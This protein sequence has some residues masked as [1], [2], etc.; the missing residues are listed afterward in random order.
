MVMSMAKITAGDGYT[1]LTRHVA[2]GD[3]PGQGMHDATAY[4][5]AQGNPPGR[6][7][8]RG[9]PL[10]G[11]DSQEVTEEQMRL[12]FGHG[13]HPDGEAMITAYINAHTHP[14]MTDV[15]LERVRQAAI[16]H[17]TLGRQFPAYKTIE[18]HGAR[19][20]RR[21][22]VIR[23]ETGRD[24]T[25]AEEKKVQA[26]ESRRHRAPVAGFDLAFTPVKSASLLWALDERP[27]VRAAIR[28]A[29]AGAITEALELIEDHAAY[30]RTGTGGIAQIATSG[31]TGA[32]F[33][34][35]DSRAGDPNLHTHVAISA[36][37]QGT[38][39]TWRALDARG[40]Y[41]LRVAASE[42]YNTA[43]EARLTAALGV[44]FAPRPG[45]GGNGKDP[46]RE[47]DGVPAV[48]IT[49]FSRRRAAIEARYDT[50]LAGYRARHGHDP[51]HAASR[52]LAQQA[53]LETR[54]HKQ[55]PRSLADKRAAWRR[56]L[57]ERFGPRATALLMAAV[58]ARPPAAP[59]SP[60]P[61]D[62]HLLAERAVANVAIRR[63]TWTRWNVHA[64][65]ERLI[66]TQ[67][68]QPD[69]RRHRALAEAITSLALSPRY[70]ISVEPPALLNEPAELRRPDGESV[71]TVHGAGRYTS[72][73]VLDAEQRLLNACRTPATGGIPWQ[74]A[75]AALDGFE[76]R[77]GTR[78]DDGQRSLVTAFACDER[79]LLAGIGP[80]GSG[81]TTAMRAFL[82]V[83]R[84]DGRRLV[85]LATSAAAADVLRR[86]LMADTEN[87]HKFLFEW[88]GGRY[89]ARLRRGRS[90]PE[91]MRMY[92][93]HP[94]DVV[95]VDE[96]SMAGTFPLDAI[97]QI[98]ASRGASVRLLGDDRQLAAV[99]TGGA[100][101]LVASQPGTPQLSV[102][103]RFDDPAEAAA[104]LQVRA[105]DGAAVEWYCDR[106]RVRSGSREA[107]AAA[108]YA[109]WKADMLAGKKTLMAAFTSADVAGLAARARAD[110]VAA[111]QVE[112]GGVTL[113]DGNLAG[114]GDWIVTR[115]NDR[116][117]TLLGATSW[118]RNGDAWDVE[119]RLPDGS[120]VV[121]HTRHR[122]RVTLPAW[123]VA[124]YVEL[125]YAMT[126][127]RAMGD[128]VDTAHP[129][130]TAGMTRE[131]LYVLASRARQSTTL[132]VA[133][134]D[135][136]FDDDPRVDRARTDPHAY[137]ARE[138][139]LNIIATEGAALPATETITIAQHE[140][141]SLATLV[142]PYLHVAHQDA[143][144]RY[145]DA[146][147]SALGAAGGTEVIADPAWAA[148][149]RRL[150]DAE[151][152]GWEPARLLSLV[153]GQRELGSAD[154]VAEVL[155]WRLDGILDA[156]PTPPIRDDATLEPG[157][158][159]RE[160][161][162]AVAG[163]VLGPQLSA[164]AQ[165]EKAWPALIAA[166][167]RAEEA[168]FDASEL[169][170][171]VA[172]PA[173]LR[174]TGNLSENLAWRV[175]RYLAAHPA[176]TTNPQGGHPAHPTREVLLPWVQR[177][178]GDG[179]D[180]GPLGQWLTEAGDLITAR[181]DELAATAVRH[182]PPWMLPL[183]Q[184]PADPE[185]ERQ[186]LGHIGIIAAYRDQQ[187][188][189][190]DDP[191]QVLGPY[192]ESGRA[193]H[194]AFWHAAESVLAARRLAGLDV[195]AAATT[196]EAQ[197]R[198]QVAADIYRSLPPDER[199]TIST[200]MAAGLGPLWFGNRT[201]P[202]ADA[203]SQPVHAA[204][205][206]STLIKHGDMTAT[207]ERTPPVTVISEPLE[208]TL[209]RRGRSQRTQPPPSHTSSRHQSPAHLQ[210]PM[211]PQPLPDQGSPRHRL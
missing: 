27:W 45:T 19:V 202:D 74:R 89:A 14:G 34:H 17:A 30:T 147:I 49:H 136:P 199:A 3:A 173:G 148:V 166:L 37:V 36:K 152:D 72:R 183:G 194:R 92:A 9:A 5:T 11:L 6:W 159:A 90:V 32:A 127:H 130:I 86:E 91:S 66:R 35:W 211:R 208:A 82:Q 206:V 107:M 158:V 141:G 197:A 196:T 104:T 120:L 209:A 108:A 155:S 171:A 98:A 128:T 22:Q 192:P 188:V 144:Q 160:R 4:Y 97:V 162:T 63:S 61:P 123:Y 18:D 170:A 76:A 46:I 182:R 51:S 190:S 184:P 53:T 201:E 112:A 75:A 43:F 119:Q 103:H 195:P 189:T 172:R 80:A 207:A 169:L 55:P 125:L 83:L 102:L 71:F 111:R 81:K 137:A 139:L 8:G 84:Q 7:I 167:R 67:S 132:Y 140:A 178:R 113:H 185:A 16:R 38:D 151:G 73:A 25:Q 135:Q 93:L 70:S 20:A 149:T 126:A 33:E 10:L 129:L 56:E 65:A 164:R 175:N 193:G 205:L 163:S 39:G 106:G 179:D 41:H 181:V 165:Q 177:P 121:R 87:L 176:E 191:R 1:Y 154:S 50:L 101:R 124:S 54:G 58:P 153:A 109:G 138:V 114:Y 68:P 116:R 204:T 203:A 42:C 145:E 117:L 23:E 118:V 88:T 59:D 99:E 95:L 79:L 133:T 168:D 21:L 180:A 15:Q 31:L 44:R 64:E 12:L 2:H 28:Q 146:A 47:I 29:H 150:Y 187:K 94:G 131:A 161:L 200:E 69:P 48:M 26:E 122:G 210:E 62:P 143:G 105:G 85:P 57:D 198:S 13:A 100:L 174:G 115:H 52:D 157:A 40:L 77:A 142:P 60:E 186:W 156:H 134:H 78:L 24:P 110:R 96:A